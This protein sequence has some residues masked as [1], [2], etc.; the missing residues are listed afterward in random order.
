MFAPVQASTSQGQAL[1]PPFVGATTEELAQLDYSL[2]SG[3]LGEA[4]LGV[5]L[6]DPR[7]LRG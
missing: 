2:E 5:W 6:L 1:G 7:F 3:N 4:G